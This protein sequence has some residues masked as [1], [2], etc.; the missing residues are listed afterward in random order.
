MSQITGTYNKKISDDARSRRIKIYVDELEKEYPEQLEENLKL[1]Y[2][3][4]LAKKI[5]DT[6]L[7]ND[8]KM[9]E[10]ID[11]V[12]SVRKEMHENQSRI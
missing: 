9:Q 3:G 1:M 5:D 2:L 7:K 11:E 8:V 12:N 10:I 4:A 6:T